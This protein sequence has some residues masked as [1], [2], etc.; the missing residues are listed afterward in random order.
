VI[1]LNADRQEFNTIEQVF[2]AEGRVNLRFRGATL[3]A[4]RL[5]VNLENRLAVADGNTTLTRGAQ[6]LRGDRLEYNLTQDEGTVIDARGELF[7]PSAGA[8]FG[9]SLPTD[10]GADT[11]PNTPVGGRVA[12]SQ[13]LQVQGSPGQFTFGVNTPNQRR[14][15]RNQ[16]DVRR[17]RY[18]ADRVDF[19]GGE[20]VAT[21]VRLTNDPF[22]P[23]ELEIR[24]RRLEFNRLSPTQSELRARNPRIVFDQGFSL[25]L[26]RDRVVFDNRERS[27]GLV[28]FGFDQDERGGLF[29]E[30][31]FDVVTTDAVSFSVTPQIYLQRGFDEGVGAS[32]LGLRSRLNAQI[33]PRTS[34]TGNVVLTSLD[35]GDVEDS[36]R[37]SLRARRQIGD[38]TLALEYSYRDRL[39]NGSLG[40]QNVQSSLG[41][42]LTSPIIPLGDSG[43]N[44]SYQAGVNFINAN[45]DRQDLL[46]PGR[47]NDRINLT[48]YQTSVALNRSFLLW[49][50]TP[51]PPTREAG[52]RYTPNP[53]TPYVALSTGVRGVVSAYSNGDTQS[54]LTGSIGLSGQFGR[55]SRDFLDYTAFNIF[56]SLT[57][58]DGESPFTFDRVADRQVLTLGITQQVYGP[59]RVGVQTSLNL[60]EG[61][62]IDTTYS[63][64]YS[65]RTYG[66]TLSYSPV[67]EAAAIGFR[68]SDF[69]WTGDPGPFSG[70]G[71]E[72]VSGGVRRETE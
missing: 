29:V 10:I 3:T 62:E 37:A 43:I 18:E 32:T 12:E 24:T 26:L 31:E 11:V 56:Y 51:L 45:T 4:D 46:E 66:I 67:R 9:P 20:A 42:V 13:P 38:H 63:I 23:P 64:E 44:L 54:S 34:F 19:A 33:D 30:R 2:R 69:N 35:L 70:L 39:F 50:G 60:D 40:F 15:G 49:T 17:L 16:G 65:R 22:S 72:P 53:I 71:A 28:T 5:Q 57:A 55:S 6:T 41:F 47:D 25:P 8:D 14:V 59:F 21:N 7:L 68:I 27:P 61:R 1:E 36:L 48:R 52:L 58:L